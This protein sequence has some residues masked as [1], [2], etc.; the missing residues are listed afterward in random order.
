VLDIES[1][2]ETATL[3]GH[4]GD[5]VQ[6]VEF[7]SDAATCI[8]GGFASAEFEVVGRKV[9]ACRF[10]YHMVSS[11][12]LLSVFPDRSLHLRICFESWR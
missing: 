11:G 8:G 10:W 2:D 7:L 4:S 3:V 1:L 9:S 6:A 12:F 5:D